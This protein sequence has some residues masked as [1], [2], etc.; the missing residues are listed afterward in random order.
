MK[1]KFTAD[2][3]PQFIWILNYFIGI[4]EVLDF[5]SW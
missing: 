2:M 4:N 3:Q 5:T 1:K